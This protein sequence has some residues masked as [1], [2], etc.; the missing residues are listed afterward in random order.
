[1][2]KSRSYIAK[3]LSEKPTRSFKTEDSTK[4]GK[5]QSSA[6]ATMEQHL[7]PRLRKKLEKK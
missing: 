2:T 7:V 4:V 6:H 5:P 3:F 1:M